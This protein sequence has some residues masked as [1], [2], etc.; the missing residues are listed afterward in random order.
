VCQISPPELTIS[1]S[2]L[3]P[4]RHREQTAPFIDMTAPGAAT[5]AAA[6]GG[7]G[8]SDVPPA[9]HNITTTTVMATTRN[10]HHAI[11]R[12]GKNRMTG[13][14]LQSENRST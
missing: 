13:L 8:A 9:L 3:K 5:A 11:S 6:G 4:L 14:L 10:N 2:L 1:S 7:A 12:R